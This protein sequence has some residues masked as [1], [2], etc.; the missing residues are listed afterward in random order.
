[1]TRGEKV[2]LG[3]VIAAFVGMLALP[4]VLVPRA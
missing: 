3:S 4:L 1:M 2:F